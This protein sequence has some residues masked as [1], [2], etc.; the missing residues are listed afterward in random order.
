MGYNVLWPLK[1]QSKY[2]IAIENSGRVEKIQIKKATWSLAGSHKYLQAR[3][4]KC[5]KKDGFSYQKEEVDFFIF[6]DLETVW[7]V[8]YEDIK[9]MTSVCLGSSNPKYR[10]YTKYDASK[11][12]IS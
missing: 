3:L 9:G 2:D 11:W 1:T 10:T 6:T 5:K 8:P 7:K 12:I 4:S